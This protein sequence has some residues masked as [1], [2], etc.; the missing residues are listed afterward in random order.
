MRK[1]F[2]IQLFGSMS[3]SGL[4]AY[5][6]DCG[7]DLS[8]AFNVAEKPSV[9]KFANDFIIKAAESGRIIPFGTI[10]PDFEGYRDEVAR[11]KAAGVRGIKFN[12]L[13]QNFYLE[14]PRMLRVFEEVE[15]QG[16]IAYFH[17]GGD[18]LNPTLPA[19][20][21]PKTLTKVME[22]FPRL[23]VIAAHFGGLF[24]LDEV[25][26]Y[27]LGRDIYLDTAWSEGHS[28]D[29]AQITQLIKRH[30]VDKIVFGSDFPTCSPRTGLE[31]IKALTLSQPEKERILSGN[32]R[33][34]LAL[35]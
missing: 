20:V 28:L 3:I 9:V 2:Q 1:R 33:Q 31:L 7:V 32:I 18:P 35:P 22:L 24:M 34:L 23:K 4:I 29:P 10:H 26:K 19:K 12:T 15:K 14:E 5:M 13:I 16:L 21:S 30:G 27:L 17:S 8:V 6:D 25:E 11:L